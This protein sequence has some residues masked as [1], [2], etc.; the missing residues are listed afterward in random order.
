MCTS[1][2]QLSTVV[3]CISGLVEIIV[4][5]CKYPSLVGKDRHVRKQIVSLEL[6]TRS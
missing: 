1:V 4:N 2:G 3:T 6:V 5:S